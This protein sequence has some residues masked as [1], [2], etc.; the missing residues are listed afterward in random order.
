MNREY[1][2]C[3]ESCQL[4]TMCHRALRP[5]IVYMAGRSIRDIGPNQQIHELRCRHRSCPRDGITAAKKSM[6]KDAYTSFPVVELDGSQHVVQARAFGSRHKRT[7]VQ[8]LRIVSTRGAIYSFQ[9][10]TYYRAG[11]I[12]EDFQN[13]EWD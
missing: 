3:R 13:N 6:Q 7:E 4:Q 1:R 11:S 9:D 2:V 5:Q 10:G 12:Y 8:R